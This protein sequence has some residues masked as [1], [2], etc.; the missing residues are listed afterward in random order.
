MRYKSDFNN[1]SNLGI[2]RLQAGEEAIPKVAEQR[3]VDFLQTVFRWCVDADVQLGDGSQIVDGVGELSIGDEECGDMFIVKQLNQAIN[4]GI[5]NRLA[6]E[7]KS[8]VTDGFGFAEA[9]GEGAG[10]SL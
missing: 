6:D 4:L 8:A 1:Q 5:H 3:A 7:G 9:F 2:E 10:H